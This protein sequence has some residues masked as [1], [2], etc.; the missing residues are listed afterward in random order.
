[1]AA[2]I[3]YMGGKHSNLSLGKGKYSIKISKS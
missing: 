1:M 2:Q 3:G